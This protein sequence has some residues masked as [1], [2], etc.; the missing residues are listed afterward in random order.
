VRLAERKTV[1]SSRNESRALE[2]RLWHD[3]AMGPR[4]W[5]ALRDSCL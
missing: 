5:K 3:L 1:V 2:Q 4:L